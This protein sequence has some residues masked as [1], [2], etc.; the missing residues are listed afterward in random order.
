MLAVT[1][2]LALLAADAYD[3]VLRSLVGAG[4]ALPSLALV[5]GDNRRGWVD[6]RR[7]DQL[8]LLFPAAR[9]R[10]RR[11]TSPSPLENAITR[12]VLAKRGDHQLYLSPRFLLFRAPALLCLSS[13]PVRGL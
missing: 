13:L 9:P 3:H 8:R 1:P 12:E 6:C 7:L 11:C 5:V 4:P 2:A 10:I